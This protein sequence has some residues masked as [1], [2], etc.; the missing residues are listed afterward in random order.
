MIREASLH[1]RGSGA[2]DVGEE[3]RDTIIEGGERMMV[4]ANKGFVFD[5]LN[6]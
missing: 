5:V 2:G 1:V 4:L 6:V 3:R